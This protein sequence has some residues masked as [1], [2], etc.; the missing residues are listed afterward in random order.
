MAC[1]HMYFVNTDLEHMLN[2]TLLMV[3]CKS[4]VELMSSKRILCL[5]L[6]K[7]RGFTRLSLL[8]FFFY[9][10]DKS[11]GS[12]P[13]WVAPIRIPHWYTDKSV[14]IKSYGKKC[15]STNVQIKAQF[16]MMVGKLSLVGPFTGLSPSWVQLSMGHLHFRYH[17][18]VPKT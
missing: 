14:V 8:L 17:I 10:S 3:F 6:H 9:I 2:E 16:P 1:F 11:W 5:I 12:S 15:L 4:W 13:M 18:V 7:S